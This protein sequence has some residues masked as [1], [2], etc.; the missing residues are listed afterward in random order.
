MLQTVP[1]TVLIY[2]ILKKCYRYKLAQN[3][4]SMSQVIF[5]A[6][7]LLVIHCSSYE[8]AGSTQLVLLIPVFFLFC[9]FFC[10]YSLRLKEKKDIKNIKITNRKAT[11]V[12]IYA[13][14]FP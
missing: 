1:A 9:F 7:C 6:I 8:C 14:F 13:V 3:K 4:M 10:I 11:V 5:I 12:Y 2:F